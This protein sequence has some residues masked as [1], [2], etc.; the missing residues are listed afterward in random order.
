MLAVKS[1]QYSV[2]RIDFQKKRLNIL[3]THTH[4][5]VNRKKNLQGVMMWHERL[6][7]KHK[8]SYEPRHSADVE[9]FVL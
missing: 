9:V 4:S 7:F 8:L 1:S 6:H 2:L 5:M 3:L